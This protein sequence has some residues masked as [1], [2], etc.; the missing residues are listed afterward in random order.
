MGSMSR[1]TV[2]GTWSPARLG[3]ERALYAW[4]RFELSWTPPHP[5]SFVVLSRGRDTRGRTQPIVPDW[6]PSG[7]LW[8]AIDQVRI[9]V[10][11]KA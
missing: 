5:G 2:A 9:N 1:P 4:R 7:Y 8:N 11:P 10:G 6:N 3:D